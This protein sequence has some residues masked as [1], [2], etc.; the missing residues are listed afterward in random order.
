MLDLLQACEAGLASKVWTDAITALNTLRQLTVHHPDVIR[1][2]LCEPA[3]V[4]HRPAAMWWILC[5]RADAH[6]AHSTADCIE[7]LRR[8]RLVPL[9]LSSVKSLRSV[10]AKAN[11]IFLPM[12]LLRLQCGLEHG[13]RSNTYS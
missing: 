8:A 5:K 10:Q 2:A 13:D 4:G 12:G 9:L 6:A 7:T 11:L 3:R 1:P